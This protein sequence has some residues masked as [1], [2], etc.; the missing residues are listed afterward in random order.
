VCILSDLLGV[1]DLTGG[2]AALP[3][4]AWS[5]AIFHL[6]HPA[7]INPDLAPGYGDFE[8]IDIE[9]G[10]KKR[11]TLT[12]RALDTYRQRLQAWQ[13]QLTRICQEKSALYS[14]IS[15]GWSFENEILPHLIK[16]RVAS[17]LEATRYGPPAGAANSGPGGRARGAKPR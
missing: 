8:L 12:A 14:M 13:D 4:P 9:T 5:V 16:M 3:L 10:Q 7:E 1:A 6:L 17:P 11:H 15:T 2:L